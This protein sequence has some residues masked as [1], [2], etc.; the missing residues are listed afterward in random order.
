[1]ERE[2]GVALLNRNTRAMTLTEAGA[3]HLAR[4]EPILAALEEADHA[5]RGTGELRGVLR[6][7]LSSSFSVREVTPRQP[8][9]LERHKS[10]RIDLGI[11]DAQRDLVTDGAD[12][13]LRL[14]VLADSTALARKQGCK[15]ARNSD[16][17]RG[18]F[19]A[20]Y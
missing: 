10:L 14:G 17:L 15:F 7:A 5:A 16:P 13:A 20:Q 1:L 8:P 6:I 4:V 12:V 19:R 3:D 18:G 9:F 11:N 2:V